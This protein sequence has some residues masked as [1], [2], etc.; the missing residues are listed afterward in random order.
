MG[1]LGDGIAQGDAVETELRTAP[2]WGLRARA[3]D[4]LLHDGRATGGTPAS[5]VSAAIAAHDGEATASAARFAGL[6][7]ANQRYL[8]DFLL[9]LGRAEFDYEGDNDV[10]ALDWTLLRLD[11]RFTGPGPHFT[12]DEPGAVADFDADGDFDLVDVAAMQ[13]AATGEL[14][15]TEDREQRRRVERAEA[16]ASRG[17]PVF[18]REWGAARVAER[19]RGP[20]GR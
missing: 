18:Q 8:V 3:V 9:S 6:R 4:E 14:L 19:R 20:N 16:A 15:G 11:G 10:D 17:R 5:N 7:L 1:S 2:L 13:R 12:A